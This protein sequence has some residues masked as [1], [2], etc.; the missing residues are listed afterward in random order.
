MLCDA[1]HATSL[2]SQLVSFNLKLILCQIYFFILIVI[3][4]F[5]IWFK[6]NLIRESLHSDRGGKASIVSV[7]VN[8]NSFKYCFYDVFRCSTHSNL[9]LKSSI[10]EKPKK[11]ELLVN[12]LELSKKSYPTGLFFSD[13]FFFFENI[14]T[15]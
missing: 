7:V 6:G 14:L 11:K 9:H 12:K 1:F 15:F 5:I 3:Y 8:L 2:S 10:L 4:S 13:M